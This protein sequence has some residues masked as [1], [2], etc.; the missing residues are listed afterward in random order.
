MKGVSLTIK[1]ICLA[2]L[3]DIFYLLSALGRGRRSPWRQEG[4]EG[5]FSI[6]KSQEGGGFS[7]EK[8]GGE[9]PGCLRGIL[10]GS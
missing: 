2:D 3:S 9:G 5:R 1:V 7:H 6:E 4:A 8:G 10:G